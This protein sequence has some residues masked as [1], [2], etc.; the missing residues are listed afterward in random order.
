MKFEILLHGIDVIKDIIDDPGDDSLEVAVAD[1]ALHR[2]RFSRRRL[3]VRE[4]GAVVSAQNI[5][6]DTLRGGAVYL[7][8]CNIRLQYLVE[9]VQFILKEKKE[10]G[11]RLISNYNR[12]R[13][14]RHPRDRNET[15][16]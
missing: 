5:F 12:L 1:N 15:V 2:V 8:L 7:F 10:T 9:H 14:I 6:D 3:P 4:N 13:L 16:R 11:S